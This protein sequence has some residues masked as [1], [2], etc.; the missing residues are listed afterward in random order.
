MYGQVM[1][2]GR[3]VN[4]FE[5]RFEEYNDIN[6]KEAQTLEK[7]CWL[8]MVGKTSIFIPNS[9]ESEIDWLKRVT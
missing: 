6:L 8:V 9:F 3:D 1:E 5:E 2:C 4:L 7:A